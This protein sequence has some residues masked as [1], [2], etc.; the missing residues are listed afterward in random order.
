LR[1]TSTTHHPASTSARRSRLRLHRSCRRELRSSD[2][3]P[4]RHH[5]PRRVG[6]CRPRY[7]SRRRHPFQ[8]PWWRLPQ[9]RRQRRPRRLQ[10]RGWS[11][12]RRRRSSHSSPHRR[13]TPRSR[14]TTA[15]GP[16]TM[17]GGG[18]GR[19]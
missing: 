1:R 7:P 8:S 2:S 19:G 13:T 5:R 15:T 6:S 17:T 10:L 18:D 12:L 9:R 11:R 4:R 16:R 14:T 3:H